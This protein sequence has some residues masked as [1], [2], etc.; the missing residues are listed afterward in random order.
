MPPEGA[1]PTAESVT[2]S[3]PFPKDS[4]FFRFF[5][6]TKNSN[7]ITIKATPA[8]LPTTLP[9]TTEVE[10][11]DPDPEPAAAAAVLEGVAL[12]G[13]IPPTPAPPSPPT[14]RVALAVNEDKTEVDEDEADEV[15]GSKYDEVSDQEKS[16]VIYVSEDLEEEVVVFEN[17]KDELLELGIKGARWC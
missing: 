1:V 14:A 15:E 11:G 2:P 10:V 12:D 5:H 13:A 6:L 8:K 17:D 7:N 4:I 16:E 9:T 3:S